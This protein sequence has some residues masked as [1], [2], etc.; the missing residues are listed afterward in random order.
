M[1]RSTIGPETGPQGAVLQ[2]PSGTNSTWNDPEDLKRRA[3]K[4]LATKFDK[5]LFSVAFGDNWERHNDRFLKAC[6]TWKIPE[7]ELVE[8]LPEIVT[9]DALNYVEAKVEDNPNISWTSLCK[10][11]AEE[12]SNV[13]R[14]KEI[15]DRLHSMRYHDF[16]QSGESP[17]TTLDSITAFIDRM[18]VLALPVDSTDEAKARFLSNLTR[19]QI[20]AYHAKG[21]ISRTATYDRIIQAFITSTRDRA[22]LEPGRYEKGFYSRKGSFRRTELYKTKKVNNESSNASSNSEDDVF[23]KED[24]SEPPTRENLICSPDTYFENA[25]FS[26]NPKHVK[27]NRNNRYTTTNNNYA[28]AANSERSVGCFNCGRQGCSVALCKRPRDATRIANNISRW[29]ELRKLDKSAKVNINNVQSACTSSYEA[30]EVM[31]SAVLISQ[32]QKDSDA[33]DDDQD[34]DPFSKLQETLQSNA[35]EHLKGEDAV[36]TDLACQTYDV[37]IINE[38]SVNTTSINPENCRENKYTSKEIK[39]GSSNF[40]GACLDKGAQRSLC[41]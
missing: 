7:E 17:A 36:T 9:K 41:G 39:Y 35:V 20:W 8:F 19:G 25:K 22:E 3:G 16:H 1:D 18:A 37:G 10:L 24:E 23:I 12:Y 31:V 13:N 27:N 5:K 40:Q 32:Y 15:S 11:L 38:V 28:N 14:Q 26:N 30:N 34:T 33:E 29:K 6:K 21:R 4:A 2:S